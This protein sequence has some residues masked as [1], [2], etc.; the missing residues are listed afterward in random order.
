MEV[1][2]MSTEELNSTL[3]LNLLDN[4]IDFILKGIDELFDEDYLFRE[5][6][7]ATAISETSTAI[8]ASA[9]KYGVLGSISLLR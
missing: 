5:Y 8:N 9:Y 6:S 2:P 3:H 1:F 7:T 4:G